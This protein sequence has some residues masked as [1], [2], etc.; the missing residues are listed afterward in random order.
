MKRVLALFILLSLMVGVIT[1]PAN[2]KSSSKTKKLEMRI[3]D[4]E[5]DEEIV[6]SVPYYSKWKA[7]DGAYGG[8][9]YFVTSDGCQMD[10]IILTAGDDENTELLCKYLKNKKYKK[11]LFEH[12]S[13]KLDVKQE[14]VSKFFK[15]KKDGSGKYLFIIDFGN[16][17]GVVRALDDNYLIAYYAYSEEKSVAKSLKKKIL[18]YI[19]Q[20]TFEKK[21]TGTVEIDPDVELLDV[22]LDPDKVIFTEVYSNMAWGYQKQ[23]L[24]VMGDG[25]VF[26]YNFVKNP[27]N[28]ENI[29]SD[30]S[31]LEYLKGTEPAAVVD[32]DYLMVMYSYAVKVN[33]D[34]EY[35]VQ[36]EMYDYGQNNLYFY[37]EDGTK[38]KVA[39]YGDVRYIFDDKYANELEKLWDKLYKH[40]K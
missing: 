25:R 12:Y 19:K 40:C 34:A 35:T 11:Q 1:V 9:Q 4:D 28:I 39:S 38:V 27:G 13:K 23:A 6:F 29:Q 16:E 14:D 20:V 32:R 26:T 3:E 33:P 10:V 18:S 17:Y 36:Q 15:L 7:E 21:S 31:P 5:T 22:Q 8:E 30:E 2:A 37:A 24:Y